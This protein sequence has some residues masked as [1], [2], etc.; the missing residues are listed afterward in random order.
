LK[1]KPLFHLRNKH[2][3]FYDFDRL[4]NI[5]PELSSYVSAN[6]VGKLSIDFANPVA[7][8]LLNKALLYSQYPLVFW[9][10]PEN[11]LCPPIPS[12]AEYIHQ[13]ADLLSN[14]N[15]NPSFKNVNILDIGTG[16]NCIYPIIGYLDY[17][18]NFVGSEI[19]LRAIEAAKLNIEKNTILKSGIEIRI[20]EDQKNIFKGIIKKED[21]FDCT[22]CNPP[23]HGSLEEAQEGSLRK[24][25]NLKGKN[26][27]ILNFGGQNSELWYKGGEI[28]FIVKMIIESTEFKN[29]CQWFT[30]LVSKKENLPRI[31]KML[32]KVEVT[33]LKAIDL[34]VGNKKSRIIAWTFS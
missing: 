28:G 18:W 8:K 21:F 34:I 4:I 26:E 12:R 20:Q 31:Y 29:Q 10:I 9:E 30:T 17:G 33:Q 2:Q 23:F 19:D 3:G 1:E 32:K 7:V 27:I 24:L 22:L 15:P 11:Y 16:A 6:K 13:I 5:L 14:G 25:K